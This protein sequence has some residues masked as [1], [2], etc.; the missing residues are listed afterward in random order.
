MTG[1]ALHD[2]L[3]RALTSAE[4]RG[5]LGAA[6][7]G[8]LGARLGPEE[9]AVLRAADRDRL[10]RLARFMAR[11][12]YRER[13]VRLF[14]ASR[15]LARRHGTDPLGLLET[16]AFGA[17]LESA[18]VGSAATAEA[19]AVLV[20]GALQAPL[21]GLPYAR[22]LLAYE[23]AL[24]RAEA[25]PRRWG[26]AAPEGGVP[27]RSPRAR[28]CGLAWDTTGLVAAV[29]RGDAEL[30]EPARV[31]TRLLVALAPSGRVTTVRCSEAVEQLLDALNGARSTA[32]VAAVVGI[33]EAEAMRVVRQLVEVG[34]VEWRRP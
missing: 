25:G 8:R 26:D 11:H 21:G 17:L 24:F 15:R 5:R 2:A 31:P 16:P 13:I 34:A 7:D 32:E 29:R 23:G 28:I 22:D 10:D 4:L 9:A 1:R 18:E 14:A 20:E 12:F 30:P 33:G 6:D 3:L 19:V 27:V